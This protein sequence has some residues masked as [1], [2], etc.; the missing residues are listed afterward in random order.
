V[1]LIA[2]LFCS[3]CNSVRAQSGAEVV[4]EIFAPDATLNGKKLDLA[5]FKQRTLRSSP[6][7]F[8][9]EIEELIAAGDR[10]VSRVSALGP[11]VR[12]WNGLPATNKNV[13][14]WAI[15]IFTLKG[16][17]IVEQWHVADRLGTLEQL[18]AIPMMPKRD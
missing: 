15:D 16:G 6:F 5:E 8:Q 13:S 9:Y 17:R 1:G 18:G 2:G 7:E 12:E 10:V 4:D 3:A 14:M 11:H